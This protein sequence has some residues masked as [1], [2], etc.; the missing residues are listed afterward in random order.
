M[1]QAYRFNTFLPAFLA[2][3]LECPKVLGCL[4]EEDLVV[5]EGPESTVALGAEESPDFSGRPVVVDMGRLP[6]PEGDWLPADAAAL[7]LLLPQR[8]KLRVGEAI[9][10]LPDMGVVL[11]L[12]AHLAPGALPGR[13]ALA[14]VEP[15][16]RQACLAAWAPFLLV[17]E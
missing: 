13:L 8:H 15:V 5:L 17:V 2:F 10:V 3:P 9:E 16:E 4:H 12:E 7:L 1:R 11:L 14:V 6:A